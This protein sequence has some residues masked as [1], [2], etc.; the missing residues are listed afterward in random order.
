MTDQAGKVNRD[1]EQIAESQRRRT[2]Y[3]RQRCAV[4]ACLWMI[5]VLFSGHW[6]WTL[7]GTF[8]ALFLVF[9]IDDELQ[10]LEHEQHDPIEF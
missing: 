2:R 4:V 10:A 5:L 7:I 1:E 6:V 8:F 9:G 3:L